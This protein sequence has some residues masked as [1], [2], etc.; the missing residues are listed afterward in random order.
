MTRFPYR[1]IDMAAWVRERGSL[2]RAK[3]ASREFAQFPI[4]D[5]NS[6]LRGAAQR[7]A[8][9]DVTGM[10]AADASD[11]CL[12]RILAK[13]SVFA[14]CFL[15]FALSFPFHLLSRLRGFLVP[16]VVIDRHRL[17]ICSPSI[18]IQ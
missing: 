16:I 3:F 7:R 17:L 2:R 9:Y 8:I 13:E 18:H 11:G 5:H 6:R 12:Q 1:E 10:P 15:L 4:V 14:F